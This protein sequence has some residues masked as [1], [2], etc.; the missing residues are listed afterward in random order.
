[1]TNTLTELKRLHAEA[2]QGEWKVTGEL[3]IEGP[4]DSST[5]FD[6]LVIGGLKGGKRYIEYPNHS[7]SSEPTRTQ[8]KANAALI[9]AAVNALPRLLACADKLQLLLQHS[10]IADV[11]PRDKDADDQQIEREAR[12][13]LAS[14]KG[15]T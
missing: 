7:L 13:A 1:M 2:T 6:P 9:V 14:L 5:D 11:D 10:G 15:G 4:R 8:G 12:A 3:G